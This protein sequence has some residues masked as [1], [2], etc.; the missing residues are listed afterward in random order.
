V[1]KNTIRNAQIN[2]VKQISILHKKE[3][4]THFLGHYSVELIEIFYKCFLGISVFIVSENKGCINGFILGGNSQDLNR[5]KKQFLNKNK[6]RYIVETVRRPQVYW[7][8]LSRIKFVTS[9][10]LPTKPTNLLQSSDQI[11]LLSI[12][13][14][15]EV[16]G[17]GLAST[18]LK[19]FEC[20]IIPVKE[21][22]L[23]VNKDN[24]RAIKFYQKNS[25]LVDK[26]HDNS[27][28]FVKNVALPKNGSK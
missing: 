21:Y 27:I 16:K 23:S 5:A 1:N 25:F 20:S 15:D 6:L 24:H 13:V 11:R 7:Q 14:S 12:A 2:D 22:G 28:Y 17:S 8:A 19:E 9:A 18:L 10:L 3:F 26:E 4:I